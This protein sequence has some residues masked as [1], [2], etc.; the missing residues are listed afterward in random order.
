M[1][2][3]RESEMPGKTEQVHMHFSPVVEG[4]IVLCSLLHSERE[5]PHIRLAPIEQELSL[6]IHAFIEE[7]QEHVT[8]DL[9]NCL[10]LTLLVPHFQNGDLF[11]AEIAALPEAEFLQG[12]IGGEVP[13]DVLQALIASPRLIYTLE[14]RY[15]WD[16]PEKQQFIEL[17]CSKLQTFQQQFAAALEHILHMGSF[18]NQITEQQKAVEH[19]LAELQ[20][21]NMKPLSLAQ[22]LM[23]KTF[24]RVSSYKL[25]YFIPSCFT[26]VRMRIF[27]DSIC[28]VIYNCT[29]PLSDD[30]K[31]SEE[32]AK[33]LKALADP[34]R[35]LILRMLCVSKEYGARLAE[36]IGLTTATVSHHLD[37][38]KK[39]KLIKEEKIGTIKYFSADAEQVK[40]M[41]DAL[42]Q[43]TA[44][45]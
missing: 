26:P 27:N 45:K 11:C 15:E 42:H 38:L 9:L 22:Y 3:E 4:I 19:S 23:G 37:L 29:K 36:Y 24:R 6:P 31:Q 33:L 30:R 25:Y 10:G 8:E 32:L 13:V 7:W 34:N 5:F 18:S 16:T 14:P 44:Q 28:I 40:R 12:F 17:L 20:Q 41:M 1:A 43:F 21:L 39:A 35:L 2:I